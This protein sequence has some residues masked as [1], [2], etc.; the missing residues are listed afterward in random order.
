MTIEE[1]IYLNKVSQGLEPLAGAIDWLLRLP[2]T[3]QLEILRSLAGMISQAGIVGTDVD[4]AIARAGLKSTF[5]PCR[6]LSAAVTRQ[7]IG[8]RELSR[9]LWTAANL[10]AAERVKTFRLFVALLDIA[11]SRRKATEE[12]CHHWWHRDLSDDDIV[13][14]IVRQHSSQPR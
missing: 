8:N 9:S 2:E 11:D 5:T 7:P 12:T 14:E 10:P 4:P 13:S 6:V 1:D 3:R